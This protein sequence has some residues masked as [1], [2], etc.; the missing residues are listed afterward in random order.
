MEIGLEAAPKT[1]KAQLLGRLL[2]GLMLVSSGVSH[3]TYLRQPFQAQVPPWVPLSP[4]LVVVLSGCVEIMLGLSL[5]ALYRRKAYVHHCRSAL[6]SGFPRKHR[7]I[8]R[9]PRGIW[10][11]DGHGSTRPAFLS[12]GSRRLGPLEHRRVDSPSTVFGQ[13]RLIAVRSRGP[14]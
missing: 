7:S 11:G 3:L 9:T 10:V 1:S 8:Y 13:T 4:D 2:L 12:A 5:M 14:L 6:C